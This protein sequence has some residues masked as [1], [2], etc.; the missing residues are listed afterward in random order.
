MNKNS[1]VGSMFVET[2]GGVV[3]V[4]MVETDRGVLPGGVRDAVTRGKPS[5]LPTPEQVREA[6]QLALWSQENSC[7]FE[8]VV[9]KN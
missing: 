2:S 8:G 6:M 7:V 5:V 1:Y 9:S 4:G 3:E